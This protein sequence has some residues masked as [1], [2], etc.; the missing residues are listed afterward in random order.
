MKI[1]T[2][3]RYALR[4]MVF[5]AKNGKDGEPVSLKRV[6]KETQISRRYLEQLAISMRNGALVRS[7]SGRKGGYI[8]ARPASEIT[9]AQIVEAA[10]GQINIVDCVLK[11]EICD[12]AGECESR[13]IYAMINTRIN[14]VL[15]E[16]TLAD[17]S[18]KNWI[19]K[20]GC[21][22]ATIG[23]NGAF[24]DTFLNGCPETAASATKD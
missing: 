2:R 19:E 6:S 1:S 23:A 13:M 11:P 18:A 21:E 5:I 20:A 17:I 8:L 3:A 14:E 10:I 4:S 12:K 22:F 24:L 16:Y 15:N 7:V 9:I